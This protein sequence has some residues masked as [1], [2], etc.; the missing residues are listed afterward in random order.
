MVLLQ[1][2][3][4]EFEVGSGERVTKGH[5]VQNFKKVYFWALMHRKRILG[6]MGCQNQGKVTKDHQVQFFFKVYFFSSYAQKTILGVM[7]GQNQVMVTKGHQVKI[8]KKYIFE[9][10]CTENAFWT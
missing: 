4:N 5:Q 2:N 9:P 6:I 10:L 3:S 8:F 1:N 7:G